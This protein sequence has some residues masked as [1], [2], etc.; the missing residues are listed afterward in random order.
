MKFALPVF[1]RRKLSDTIVKVEKLSRRFGLI[2][3]LLICWEDYVFVHFK[4]DKEKIEM[5]RRSEKVPSRGST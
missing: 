5:R 2:R 4:N 1:G 3:L